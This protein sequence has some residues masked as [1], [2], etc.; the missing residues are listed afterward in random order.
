MKH[1]SESI[2]GRKGISGAPIL[3]QGDIIITRRND[4]Y[5]VL[6]DQDCLKKIINPDSFRYY[7]MSKGAYVHN[8]YR[9]GIAGFMD[10]SSFNDKLE[11]IGGDG[12]Y[13]I[14]QIWRNYRKPINITSNDDIDQIIQIKNLKLLK[15]SY[16]LIWK[17]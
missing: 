2:I 9:G 17:R 7:D 3:R 8:T 6:T 14:I 10:L 11:E 15:E 12:D 16:K 4:I 13:D 1:I 5:M